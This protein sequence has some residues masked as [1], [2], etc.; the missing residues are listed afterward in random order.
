MLDRFC[1]HALKAI[2][3]LLAATSATA[4]NP[5]WPQYRGP[6]RDGISTETGLFADLSK[7]GPKPLWKAKIGTGYSSVAVADGLAYVSGNVKDTDT[8]FCF[9]ALTGKEIWRHSYPCKLIDSVSSGAIGGPASTPTVSDGAVY[10]LSRD[11]DVFRFEARTGKVIWGKNLA[12]EIGAKMTYGYASSPVIAGNLVIY[13]MNVAGVAVHKETGDV[14][15][16]SDA[17]PAGHATPILI[18]NGPAQRVLITGSKSLVAVDPAS[19]QLAWDYPYK[20]R[21]DPLIIGQTMFLSSGPNQENG[22]ALL[23]LAASSAPTV[24]WK[25]KGVM[26]TYFSTCVFLN[27]YLYGPD[28][29]KSF[30]C[31]DARTGELKWSSDGFGMAGA[32]YADGKLIMLSENGELI[33]AE[34]TPEAYTELSRTQVLTGKCYTMPSLCAGKL[35][36]RSVTGDLVCL[37]VK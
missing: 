20:T 15:W 23:N 7:A 9:D 21:S 14:A 28:N 18:G 12:Q 30:Q 16:K 4:A 32:I 37:A 35:Y 11:G 22:C 10:A 24:V 29:A 1:D 33:I 3:I 27:G 13:N 8:I 34:A 36:C 6:N 17:K 19:G 26:R 2:L 5:E 31:I 25:A